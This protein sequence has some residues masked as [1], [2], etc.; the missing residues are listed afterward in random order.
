MNAAAPPPSPRAWR[1][2]HA[3]ID[4]S[5]RLALAA[6]IAFLGVNGRRLTFTN[7]SAYELVMAAATGELEDVA[8]IAARIAAASEPR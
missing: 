5:K 6:I 3:L 1:R 4:P 2:N 7:E 8:A